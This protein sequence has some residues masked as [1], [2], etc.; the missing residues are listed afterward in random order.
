[1]IYFQNVSVGYEY[2]FYYV[3]KFRN[4]IGGKIKSI[5]LIEL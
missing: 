3:N 1:M 5:K 4:Y 2:I